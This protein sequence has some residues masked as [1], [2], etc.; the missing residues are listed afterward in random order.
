MFGSDLTNKRDVLRL[1]GKRTREG[2]RTSFRAL[3]EELW[4][5]ADAACSHLK[6]LWRERLIRSTEGPSGY[7]EAARYK[8]SIR[9]LT[10]RISRRGVERLE[11]WK[12][13]EEESQ[14]LS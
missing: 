11:H 9:D 8:T 14:W 1:I 5:S 13:L 12:S 3:E 7:Q 6:R 4:L 10:F 2:K